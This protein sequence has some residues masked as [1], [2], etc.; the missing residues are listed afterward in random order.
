MLKYRCLRGDVI[1]IFKIVHNF[2]HLEAALKL[3]SN[4]FSITTG[5]K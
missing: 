5:N 2:Y 4:T 1:D 3:N